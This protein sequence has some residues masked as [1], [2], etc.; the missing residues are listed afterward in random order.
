MTPTDRD[1]KRLAAYVGAVQALLRLGQWRIEINRDV[2]ADG[3]AH[4]NIEFTSGKQQAVMFVAA[5][6][7][8][9][10]ADEKRE[11]VTH[12]LLHAHIRPFDCLLTLAIRQLA[13]AAQS[14]LAAE[15]DEREE[16]LVDA[17]TA[18][19]APLMPK[20]RGK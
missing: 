15:A 2:P 20:W 9:L 7:W 5:D 19:V 3:G 11:H 14:M 13:P 8:T 10:K 4:V 12:E 6:F 16:L 18:A 1:W 17:L